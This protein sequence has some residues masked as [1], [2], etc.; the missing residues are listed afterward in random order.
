MR[1]SVRLLSPRP[2][3]RAVC[4]YMHALCLPNTTVHVSVSVCLV[5]E[6]MLTRQPVWT[7]VSARLCGPRQVGL[8]TSGSIRNHAHAE[9]HV[10]VHLYTC[11]QTLVYVYGSTCARVN[12]WAHSCVDLRTPMCECV[13]VSLHLLACASV[14]TYTGGSGLILC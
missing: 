12:M 10:N 7:R 3:V 2:R 13:Y 8:C 14:C 4:T 6:H 5:K 9:F 11:V 1:V